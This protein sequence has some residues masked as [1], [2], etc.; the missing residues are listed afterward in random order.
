MTPE[1]YNNLVEYVKQG[2]RVLMTAAHLDTS[3]T[4]GEGIKLINNGNVEELFGCRLNA[5]ESFISNSG[6]KFNESIMD[7]VLYP[8]YRNHDPRFASGYAK[9]AKTELCG[10]VVASYLSQAFSESDNSDGRTAMVEHKLGDGCAILITGIEYPGNGP[11][12]SMYKAVVR[13]LMTASHRACDVKVYGNDRL[14][15]SVYEGNKVYL[16]NTDLDN[17]IIVTVERD[18]NKEK[19][20]LEPGELRGV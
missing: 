7:G 6:F 14:R 3:V 18:G 19:F 16:L 9:Y 4:R 13:E 12:Y 8:V 17:E 5:E 2:G 20:T 1:I 15:F 10:G 11:L